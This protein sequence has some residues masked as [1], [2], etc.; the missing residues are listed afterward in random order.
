MVDSEYPLK[1]GSRLLC[2]PV[3]TYFGITERYQN[4]SCI[5]LFLVKQ[6]HDSFKNIFLY[7]A[8]LLY[9]QFLKFWFDYLHEH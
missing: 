6:A 3:I 2:F 1:E 8:L 7:T 5:N 9:T 4:G